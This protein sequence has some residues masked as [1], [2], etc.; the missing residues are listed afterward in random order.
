MLVK[1]DIDLHTEETTLVTLEADTIAYDNPHFGTSMHHSKELLED[2]QGTVDYTNTTE[3][4]PQSPV[5]ISQSPSACV[6]KAGEIS[7]IKP[8]KKG[9]PSPFYYSTPG[10]LEKLQTGAYSLPRSVGPIKTPRRKPAHLRR[11]PGQSKGIPMP[12]PCKPSALKDFTSQDT[13]LPA[14]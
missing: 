1:P 8:V 5:E 2:I 9:A 14:E 12:A 7:P 3:N 10:E 4:P 6:D 11:P 13:V